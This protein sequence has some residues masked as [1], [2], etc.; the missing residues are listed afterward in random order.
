MNRKKGI[1]QLVLLVVLI[2]FFA[3]TAINGLGSDKSGSI[4]DI[5]QGLDLAGGVSIT[6]TVV[7]D[8][9]S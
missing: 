6:Y 7:D 2:A 8:N 1:W 4:Y 5:K 9:P 3:F